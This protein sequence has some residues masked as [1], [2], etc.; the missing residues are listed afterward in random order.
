MIRRPP[1]STLFPYTTLF[2]SPLARQIDRAEDLGEQLAGRPDERSP[3]FVFHPSGPFPHRDQAGLRRSF[4]WNRVPAGLPQPAFW[5]PPPPVLGP[6]Q[7]DRP[8]APAVPAPKPAP[9]VQ[10][11]SP[12]GGGPA[13]AGVG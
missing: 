6:L 12:P 7:R 8:C 3:G 10:R 13:P 5:A 9:G 1:R 2:R 11:D 4:P